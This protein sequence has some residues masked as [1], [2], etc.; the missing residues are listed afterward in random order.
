MTKGL[1]TSVKV[2]MHL[3]CL[4]VY[5]PEGADPNLDALPTVGVKL[6]REQAVALARVLLAGA[7][8]WDEMELVAFRGEKSKDATATYLLAVVPQH[9]GLEEGVDPKAFKHKVPKGIVKPEETEELDEILKD[10]P[11]VD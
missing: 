1:P 9:Y 3:R 2:D 10:F 8:E 6:S 7:Q 5:P 11:T 4:K